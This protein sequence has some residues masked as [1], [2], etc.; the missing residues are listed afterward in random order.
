VGQRHL[1]R[2]VH[3]VR[4]QLSIRRDLVVEIDR[5]NGHSRWPRGS[6]SR[7]VR[8]VRTAMEASSST[9]PG[10]RASVD[11]ADDRRNQCVLLQHHQW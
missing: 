2:E 3:S 8:T 6:S 11:S 10:V 5:I 1:R 7:S 9:T 4:V